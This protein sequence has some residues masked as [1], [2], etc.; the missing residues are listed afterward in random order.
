VEELDGQVPILPLNDVLHAY[1][2]VEL[3]AELVPKVRNGMP[4]QRVLERVAPASLP[5]EGYLCLSRQGKLIAVVR[6]K[7]KPGYLRVFR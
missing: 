5:G 6:T 3:S 4:V 7:P 1:P 2:H